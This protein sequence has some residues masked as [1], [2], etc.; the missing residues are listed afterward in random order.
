M[1]NNWNLNKREMIF[2]K[3]YANTG[4]RQQSI[5]LAGY[6]PKSAR[7]T[8]CR[9][10]KKQSIKDYMD[11][12]TQKKVITSDYTEQDIVYELLDI[13]QL[14]KNSEEYH[15]AIRANELLGKHKGMFKEQVQ[16][17]GNIGVYFNG[18][19]ELKD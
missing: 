3:A 17:S 9:L 7:T 12:L 16:H 6:S 19:N 15:A 13:S 14:A 4:N 18:E 11:Y 5:E 8:A 10:L 2:C 1:D